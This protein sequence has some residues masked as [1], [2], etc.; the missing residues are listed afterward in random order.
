VSIE[1]QCAEHMQNWCQ[2]S[3]NLLYCTPGVQLSSTAAACYSCQLH[4]D[5]QY[6]AFLSWGSALSRS[7]HTQQYMAMQMASDLSYGTSR[8]LLL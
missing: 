4:V 8:S 5:R 7:R 3:N 1:A 2:A 6:S